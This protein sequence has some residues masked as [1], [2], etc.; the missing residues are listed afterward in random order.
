MSIEELFGTLQQSV[1]SAWRKH[2]RTAKYSKHMALDEFYN[3][4]PEKVDALIEAWMGANG[5]KIKSYD[6]I[7][8]SKNMN[9]LSYLKELRKIVKQGYALMNEEAEL[10]AKLDD[11][12]ELIDST[13]YKVKELSENNVIDLKD[14]INESLMVNESYDFMNDCDTY[15]SNW[16]LVDIY[17]EIYNNPSKLKSYDWSDYFD[18]DFIET[19]NKDIIKFFINFFAGIAYINNYD[20]GN[21]DDFSDEFIREEASIGEDECGVAL[22]K[23][24]D[25]GTWTIIT[26]KKPLNKLPKNQ[27]Q[28][29]HTLLD[30]Y[31]NSGWYIVEYF[32]AI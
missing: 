8:Q 28:A 31:D 18:E 24:G 6:N 21:V 9:T 4:M 7:L 5:K 3:E 11:I 13:L 16:D 23:D 19:H 10:E 20:L 29:I 32:D 15:P 26:F 12:V 17:D 2:L 1:V 25:D 27:Q 14:L 22:S 30:I